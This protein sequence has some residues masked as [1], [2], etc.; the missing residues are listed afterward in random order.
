MAVLY[1]LETVLN[2]G[3]LG[4]GLVIDFS[5]VFFSELLSLQRRAGNPQSHRR[6]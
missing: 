5:C 1:P 2:T 3:V 6:L 4:L